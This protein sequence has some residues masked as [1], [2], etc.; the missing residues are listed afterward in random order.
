MRGPARVRLLRP[1]RLTVRYRRRRRRSRIPGPGGIRPHDIQDGCTAL[2]FR[3]FTTF[4]CHQ[5]TARK[6]SVLRCRRPRAHAEGHSV[7]C[8]EGPAPVR[9]TWLGQAGCDVR[10]A[11]RTASVFSEHGERCGGA[12]KG[13]SASTGAAARPPRPERS[14]PARNTRAGAARPRVRHRSNGAGASRP[15]H[16]RPAGVISAE[17]PF[18]ERGVLA[19]TLPGLMVRGS[20]ASPGAPTS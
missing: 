17:W 6:D 19:P 15:G 4:H 14:C 3:P 12:G 18:W 7:G 9:E 1:A 16:Y 11:T 20:T 8:E 10:P 13:R 5:H 2:R